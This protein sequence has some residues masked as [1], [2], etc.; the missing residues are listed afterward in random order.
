VDFPI[1]KD[2]LISTL[3]P[4]A[5]GIAAY[6]GQ[7]IESE[8][9]QGREF[10]T[11]SLET[12]FDP[13]ADLS[14]NPASRP[15][16]TGLFRFLFAHRWRRVVL[17]YTPYFFRIDTGRPGARF[18]L[19]KL[20]LFFRICRWRAEE[21]EIIIHEHA[22]PGTR[23]RL[24]RA[25]D[26]RLLALADRLVFHTDQDRKAF[27]DLFRPNERTEIVIRDHGLH[28][29]KN[30]LSDKP[31]A[32]AELGVAEDALLFVCA[33]FIQPN[34]GFD[35][36]VNA[37]AAA[38]N[39]HREGPAALLR[40]VGDCREANH[41]N[42]TCKRELLALAESSGADVAVVADFVSDEE[43]DR[44]I[45][46]SDYV[47]LPYRQIWS[48]GVAARAR[49]YE[50]PVLARSLPGLRDQLGEN[51]ALW[52]RTDEELGSIME[53]VIGHAAQS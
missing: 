32:R 13:G 22:V 30:Y 27:L 45:C 11:I 8:R 36:A 24:E 14:L 39:L 42:V 25:F 29:R 37:F 41:E 21:F 53:D 49:L 2:L 48:S 20:V 18:A 16:W 10:S 31:A 50:K 12:D 1:R 5:C 46:A 28:F 43:F 26:A 52:F 33:G 47:V 51:G 35:C 34:K 19:F 17:N 44:W 7:L 3:P 23:N 38:E 6:A 40:I 4:R 9:R 15:D